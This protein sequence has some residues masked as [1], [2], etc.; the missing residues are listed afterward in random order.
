MDNRLLRKLN[1][2]LLCTIIGISSVSCTHESPE[3]VPEDQPGGLI[4]KMTQTELDRTV[5][6]DLMLLERPWETT[7]GEDDDEYSDLISGIAYEVWTVEDA[8]T[9]YNELDDEIDPDELTQILD[10]IEDHPEDYENSVHGLVIHGT[11]YFNIIPPVDYDGGAGSIRFLHYNPNTHENYIN[12][13]DFADYDELKN[14]LSSEYDLC[15][16]EG[17]MTTAR[18]EEE[19]GDIVLFFD[20]LIDGDVIRLELNTISN[21]LDYY[22]EHLDTEETADSMYWEFDE[23]QVVEIKDSITEYH[24]YD[25]ELDK[26]Y[27]VHVTTPP[28]YD[29]S[30]S[31]GALVMTD[32]VWRFKDV[33]TLYQEMASGNADPKLLITIGQD[34]QVDSW[35]NEIRSDDFCVHKKE[36]LDFITDNMMPY[37]AENYIIDCSSSCLFGHSQGG[38]FTHYAAFSSDLYENQPFAEYIIGSPAFWTPY[39]TCLSDWDEYQNEYGYFERNNS[40]DKKIYIT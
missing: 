1:T 21:Y 18:A 15:V 17:E 11:P 4:N 16:S 26:T 2:A 5:K 13:L 10:D 3:P 33:Y 19:Y 7:G 31:Y 22:Y 39:F 35:D 12:T 25:E 38:I 14:R 23:A 28:E 29:P 37:L 27:I 34:Y 30:I 36:F 24:F 8:I 32:A 9:Y 40:F 6:T 20:A